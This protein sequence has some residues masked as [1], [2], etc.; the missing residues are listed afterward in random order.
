MLKVARTLPL[1]LAALLA[2]AC[3][4]TDTL[5]GDGDNG[6]EKVGDGHQAID[7]LVDSIA[8][9]VLPQAQPKSEVECNDPS[10]PRTRKR[11]TSSAPTST[12][13]RRST[14]TSSWPSSPTRRPCGPAS[15]S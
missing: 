3:A 12:I 2:T 1:L 13:P 5:P 14:T 6:G 8:D 9:L 4:S 15:L 7:D 10:C 11:A